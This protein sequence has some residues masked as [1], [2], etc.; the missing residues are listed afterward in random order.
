MKFSLRLV[1]LLFPALIFALEPVQRE[2]VQNFI[3]DKKWPEARARLTQCLA[4]EPDNAELHFFLG[5]SYLYAHEPA[6]AVP[7]LERATALDPANSRYMRHLGDAYGLSAQKAGIFSKM[8]WAKKCKAAYEKA[9]ELD[10]KDIGARWSVMEYC[11]QAPGFVGGGM[12]Q[13]YAQATAIKQL[14][15]GAGRVA[16]ASLY[17]AEKKFPEAF[18]QFD[19]ALQANPD[20]YEV[21]F[22]VGRLADVTSHDL[23]RGLTSLRR[24]LILPVPEK[25]S[26]H[27]TAQLLIGNILLK[28]GDQAAARA[29]YEAALALNP[30]LTPATEALAKLNGKS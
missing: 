22:Q 8:G 24:C 9:V 1:L 19:D 17:V 3:R 14:N 12:D 11:R 16:F 29:A 6:G 21:L 7:A 25:S 5:Q 20:D 13:A 10:P 15:V 4:A 26:G 23:P 2:E 27:A 30:Q 18:A 28:Q